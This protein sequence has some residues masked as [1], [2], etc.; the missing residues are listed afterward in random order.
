MN[1]WQRYLNLNQEKNYNRRLLKKEAAEKVYEIRKIW[2]G[3]K[4][5]IIF[6]Y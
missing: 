6:F 4:Y 2:Y 5:C 3:A 1:N